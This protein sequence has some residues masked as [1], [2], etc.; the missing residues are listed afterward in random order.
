MT[1]IAYHETVNDLQDPAWWGPGPFATRDWFALLETRRTRPLYATAREGSSRVLL[2]L[3]RGPRGLESLANWYAFTWQPLLSGPAAPRLL[4]NLARDLRTNHARIDFAGVPAERDVTGILVRAFREGGWRVF[5]EAADTNHIL[6]PAG[7]PFADYLATRPG[8]LRTTLKRKAKAVQTQIAT[9]FSNEDW[10]AFEEIYAVSWKPAEG[11]P[12]FLRR[13]AIA[14][15]RKGHFLFGLARHDGEPVAA[16]FWTIEN[17]TA[18][19]HK[20][21][22]RQDA[23][24]LSPGSVLTA[25]LFEHALDAAGVDCVDFGTGNDAYKADWMEETRTRHRITCLD[26]R[27]PRT[28]PALAR[29]IARKL[30]PAARGG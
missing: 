16:Q 14:Q 12:D 29:R 8:R 3:N 17:G 13:F 25:A 10:Q 1:T 7:R 21:A 20:L 22:H 24:R 4:A 11:D 28:W 26:P 23:T 18:F 19:I 15:S 2:P 9:T 6:R 27:T 5:S 30:V